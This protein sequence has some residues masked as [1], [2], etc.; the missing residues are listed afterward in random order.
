MVASP[1]YKVLKDA[2]LRTLMG[3]GRELNCIRSFSK[4]EMLMTLRNGAEVICRSAEDPDML[5]GPNLSGCW[6][7]EAGEMKEEAFDITIACLRENGEQG[8]LASTFTP[9]GY[10]HWTYKVF[11]AGTMPDAALYR[12]S[13][14]HNPFLPAGFYDRVRHRYGMTRAAQE[15]DGLF[16]NI[17]GA[18]FD[19]EWFDDSMWFRDWPDESQVKVKTMGWDPSVGKKADRGDYSSVVQLMV[20]HDDT[21]W[22]EAHLKRKNVVWMI[23]YSLD[24]CEEWRPDAFGIE[25]NGFQ[26]L[27][28]E[29]MRE[30]IR[31]RNIATDICTVEN[32]I[33]K[34]I[35]I[36]R[37]IS[38]HSERRVRYRDTPDTRLLVEQLQQFPNGDHD[39]G[40]DGFEMAHRTALERIG[41]RNVE[42]GDDLVWDYELA[43]V[44]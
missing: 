38:P 34:E 30:K 39:D 20:G 5:R 1:T 11:G 15:L 16:V 4:T 23:D 13:T 27:I 36:R 35:R 9:K 12:C 42:T 32:T 6:F 18:E 29:P 7:D 41:T 25:T 3:M 31:G 19:Q 40:P 21:L 28:A 33:N 37:L 26:E 14:K 8:W 10:A 22:V 24:L 44:L 17:D 43:G 2:T